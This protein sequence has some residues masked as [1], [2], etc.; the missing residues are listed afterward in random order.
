MSPF[1][2]RVLGP[3]PKA[4][5]R[6]MSADQAEVARQSP[7][8]RLPPN[9]EGCFEHSSPAVNPSGEEKFF[10]FLLRGSHENHHH[11]HACCVS[12]FG[13]SHALHAGSAWQRGHLSLP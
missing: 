8:N 3:A 11:G 12:G 9:L 4:L 10:I 7:P 13:I 6:S 5:P 1:L 2:K